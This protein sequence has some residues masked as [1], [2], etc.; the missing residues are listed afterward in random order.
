MKRKRAQDDLDSNARQEIAD[1]KRKKDRSDEEMRQELHITTIQRQHQYQDHLQSE[2][3]LD[4]ISKRQVIS[5]TIQNDHQLALIRASQDYNKTCGLASNIFR[6]IPNY[7]MVMQSILPSMPG[8]SSTD[9][10]VNSISKDQLQLQQQ[11]N[12]CERKDRNTFNSETTSSSNS[13]SSS[14]ITIINQENNNDQDSRNN[15]L[16]FLF[17]QMQD[18]ENEINDIE[19]N[20]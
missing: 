17:K 4:N 7:N 14:N 9:N 1:Y 16:Q 13:S 15:R 10:F 18:A 12:I 8:T 5:S 11:P 20:K 2:Q 3:K 6:N 19:K